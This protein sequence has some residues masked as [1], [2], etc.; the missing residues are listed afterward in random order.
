MEPAK[1][2]F[3]ILHNIVPKLPKICAKLQKDN[4]KMYEING[5][6]IMK[7]VKE[8]PI[9][10]IVTDMDGTLLNSHD[11]ISEET[12]RCLIACEE[13]GI[14]LI[15]A[16]GR[17]YVR[18]MP[19]VRQLRMEE[20]DGCLIE[21]NGL[22]LNHLNRKERQVFSQLYK[23][24]IEALFYFLREQQIEIQ[25]YKDDTFY[26]WIPDWQIPYKTAEREERGYLKNHPLAGSA[27]SW[28]ISD[29][30]SHNYPNIIEASSIEEL[31]ESINKL[32]C[33]DNPDKI[34]QVCQMVKEKF[35]DICEVVRTSPRLIEIAPKGIT[36][37]KTL[38]RFMEK[39]K[40][41]PEEVI[42]FGDGEND[43]DMFRQVA[44]SIAMGNAAGYVKKYASDVTGTNDEDGVA[45][46]LK[47]Y[48][49]L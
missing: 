46:S 10:W 18:L 20:Y 23:K 19:Y 2:F 28:I 5:T 32:N 43:V 13:K 40:I 24:D 35:H 29:D 4:S 16:S 7:G 42:A 44:Y 31:P 49:V 22:A 37:G 27:W 9:K 45:A 33:L 26:Y 34:D 17:S 41:L 11:R 8:M 30:F 25:A 6:I 38:R 15:L 47:K 14:R 12:E 1:L 48:G 36:K 3:S 39:E 21:I